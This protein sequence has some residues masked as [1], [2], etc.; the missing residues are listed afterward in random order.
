VGGED[1]GLVGVGVLPEPVLQG[2]ELDHGVVEGLVEEAALL[3]PVGGVLLDLD[4]LVEHPHDPPDPQAGRGRHPEQDVRVL[5]TPTRSRRRRSGGGG[6][7]RDRNGALLP[8]ALPEGLGELLGRLSGVR[9]VRGDLDLVSRQHLQ[10]HDGHHALRVRLVVTPFEPDDALILLR[11]VGQDGRRPRVQALRVRDDDRVRGHGAARRCR[12][13]LGRA[14]LLAAGEGDLGDV[15]G[16]CGHQARARR[17]RRDEVRIG[18]HHLREQALGAGGHLVQVEADELVPG[19][20]LVADLDLGVEALATHLHRVET[21][22]QQHLEV[23]Q[24]PDG[25]RMQGGMQITDLTVTRGDEM[26]AQGV[27]RNTLTDHLLGEDRVGNLLNRHQDPRQRGLQVKT[28]HGRGRGVHRHGCSPSAG[29]DVERLRAAP[30]P[31]PPVPAGRVAGT[32]GQPLWSRCEDDACRDAAGFDV[33]DRLVD[34][35]E[36]PQL[37]DHL[38]LAGG[39]QLEHHA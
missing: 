14:L 26:I 30:R 27:D 35:V 1:R 38:R 25:D 24:G 19:A 16:P 11:Q 15:V 18:D 12:R 8:Q 21:D 32:S 3:V 4:V 31:R 39:V 37:G 33:C 28:R 5:G 23:S 10:A 29:V 2:L 7:L 9:A 17:E 6:G 34:G 22:V 36:W 20:D 13:A